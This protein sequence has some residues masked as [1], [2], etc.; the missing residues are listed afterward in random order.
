MRAYRLHLGEEALVYRLAYNGD[1]VAFKWAVGAIRR[2]TFR[3]VFATC[4][5]IGTRSARSAAARP[6]IVS[7]AAPPMVDALRRVR[8][9]MSRRVFC[10]FCHA[11]SRVPMVFGPF[12]YCAFCELAAPDAP[13]TIDDQRRCTGGRYRTIYGG[14]RGSASLPAPAKWLGP[15]THTVYMSTPRDRC[16]IRFRQVFV[17]HADTNDFSIERRLSC[18][19]E[20][21]VALRYLFWR[22]RYVVIIVE[23]CAKRRNPT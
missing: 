17:E 22:E 15:I 5:T 19:V 21:G 14:S 8:R 20:V 4:G 2:G 16:E 1:V 10:R 3:R 6:R 7:G 12:H 13:E 18:I 9:W 11:R 23:V